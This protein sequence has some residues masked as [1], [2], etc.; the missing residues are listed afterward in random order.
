M[1]KVL[2]YFIIALFA[3]QLTAFAANDMPDG[4]IDDTSKYILSTV[5][6]PDVGSV[7]GEWVI[8]GLA[9]SGAD[10]PEAYY[11]NYYRRVEKYIA[12]GKLSQAYPTD[13]ARLVLAL[14]AIGKDPSNISGHNLITPLCDYDKILSQGISAPIWAVIALDS[15]KYSAAV[16]E[17]YIL[18]ILNAQNADGGW[19][20]DPNA[21]TS[22]P[23]LT[24]TA[25][26]ALSKHKESERVNTAIEKALS[27]LSALQ[28]DNGGFLSWGS[29]S[30]ESAAQVLTA[31]CEL[32]IP[33]DDSRFVKNGNTVL[34][35]LMRFYKPQSGFS[36]A[37]NEETNQ[38][39]TEQGFYALAAN[40]RAQN[41]SKTL[42]DLSDSISVSDAEKDFGLPNKN[43]DISYK[44]VTSYK[45]FDDIKGNKNQA[46]IEAL[47]SRGIINGMTDTEFKP[48]NTMTRAEFA[49]IT[50]N[51]LGLPI[52]KE[53]PFKDVNESDWFSDYV[54]AAYAYGII[55]GVSDTEF[56][57][58]GTI[59]REEAMAMI[60][61]LTDLTG[62]S[63][64]LDDITAQN[65]L[66]VFDDY[67][68]ISG[69]AVSSSALCV[70]EGII[71]GSG[72]EIKPKEYVLRAEIAHMLFRVM[73]RAELI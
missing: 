57:P 22:D 56:N 40:M 55:S 67:R 62:M 53:N 64:W 46:E 12:D 73:E 8:F 58:N 23:D 10:V 19:S 54:S 44:N 66:A 72:M 32:N 2:S 11:Q 4:A 30:S 17:N 71:D 36:H 29:E 27:F 38:I 25:L 70:N 26:I 24:G 34:D 68:T 1:K 18:H 43:A 37:L 3:F 7:G 45:T 50:V 41:G 9:R 65:V 13:Y 14:G 63:A 60:A 5:Q 61:R 42:Y 59:T 35:N 31:M 21:E 28:S 16:I 6:N 49:T 48:D 33:L 47:A 39:S 69:W 15:R 52:K 51:A 20:F